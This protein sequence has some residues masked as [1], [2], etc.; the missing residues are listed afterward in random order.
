MFSGRGSS[1]LIYYHANGLVG[2][3]AQDYKDRP[4]ECGK[5]TS[6]IEDIWVVLR[7]MH[8]KDFTKLAIFTLQREEKGLLPGRIVVNHWLLRI[9]Y[10]LIGTRRAAEQ[11]PGSGTLQ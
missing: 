11:F 10:V 6:R 1:I 3:A 8:C 2:Q 4:I 7:E 9:C 5:M